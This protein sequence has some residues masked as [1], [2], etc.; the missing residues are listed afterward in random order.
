MGN[1]KI[2]I[3]IFE[4][5]AEP[6]LSEENKQSKEKRFEMKKVLFNVLPSTVLVITLI[7]I[8]TI[9]SE[10]SI[11]PQ[12]M[13]PAPTAV[14]FAFCKNFPTLFQ[15]SLITLLETL[16]GLLVSIILAF[17]SALLMDRFSII[18]RAVQPLLIVTQTVPTIAVAPIIVLF[19]GYGILPKIILVIICCFFP[20]TIALLDG[21]TTIDKG[22]LNLLKCM[23]AT[24]MQ[25]LFHL[26]MPLATPQ[27]FSGL[28]I[29]VT[30]AFISAV[31]A[32]WLG[33]TAGLGVYMTRVKSAYA[34]DK[35]FAS[36]IFISM[37]SFLFIK[38]IE[39][40]RNKTLNRLNIDK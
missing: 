8:W 33:G 1:S 24:Y 31:V 39:C 3:N 7:L 23:N 5:T 19:F 30:Y 26:K 6:T 38:T 22:Y 32:E 2:F 10:L 25:T 37:I 28:K 36:I 13:L 12:F 16:I 40:I 4:C 14:F 27:F 20:V 15:H 9:I 35:L 34:F 29:A 17:L 18:K 11:I 21:F